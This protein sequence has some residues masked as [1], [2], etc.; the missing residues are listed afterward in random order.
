MRDYQPVEYTYKHTGDLNK[1][2]LEDDPSNG[3]EE[4]KM[5]KLEDLDNDGG[6][7]TDTSNKDDSDF[8]ANNSNIKPLKIDDSTEDLVDETTDNED[9]V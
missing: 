9:K 5:D 2:N 7:D 4:N 3:E 1:I 8:N 6:D